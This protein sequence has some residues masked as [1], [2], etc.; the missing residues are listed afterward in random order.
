MS[1]TIHILLVDDNLDDVELTIAFCATAAPHLKFT[2]VETGAAVRAQLHNGQSQ[3]FDALVFDYAL[4]D[5][6]GFAL[7]QDVIKT[8]YLAPVI[9]VTGRDDV[10]TAVKAMKQGATDYLVKSSNYW[11]YI[12]RVIESAI[13]RY[14]LAEENQRLQRELTQRA[15]ELEAAVARAETEQR[16]LQA[17]LDQLPE[18]VLIADGAHGEVV[19]A[20]NVAE[21]IFGSA[22][23]ADTNITR[24]QD[25]RL[26]QLDETPIAPKETAIFHALQ[27]GKTI[28]GN[29]I[30]VVKPDGQRITILMN[31]APLFDKDGSVTGAVSVF[32][33]ITELKRLEA[34]KD[35]ILS[36]ASHELKNPLTV[37]MGY[38]S[39]LRQLPEITQNNR[40]Q[41]AVQTIY[42]Q[43]QRMLQLINRLLDL[44]RLDLD[45]MTLQMTSFD[46]VPL[47]QTCIE[48]QQMMAS[49]HIIRTEFSHI[50]LPVMA[51]HMRIEQV[52]VNLLS[53]AIKYSPHGGEID[54]SLRLS[55]QITLID[56]IC[57]SELP[58]QG[59]FVC[60]Q[61][62]DAGIGI[63][64][65]DLQQ[66][67]RRFYRADD[68][69]Q[70]VSG[71]GLGLYI[72][73]EIMRLHGGVL[74]VESTPNQG[75]TFYM[76]LPLT[77]TE[78]NEPV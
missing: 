78:Q 46:I 32:Q 25:Y 3:H 73:S 2:V 69:A 53:N 19:A 41:R 36:I 55:D 58:Q 1:N 27:T 63:A 11:Q 26:E 4:P 64:P 43:S 5:T 6:T 23:I 48:E 47:I 40:A 50:T 56:G 38:A 42:Q 31:T 67:F 65:A 44:S 61:V 70:I 12:P 9:M 54:V 49:N 24:E 72:S 7:L 14:H 16:R 13:E 8:K 33:D 68:A 39:L 62:R 35:E 10:E 71:Q 66:L 45:R 77:L 52:L 57:G 28:L 30:V 76:V 29:Q 37:V 15:A 75:S 22:L 59:S 20:N 18:G 17:V 74:C 51:D 60:I 34:L 21:Q